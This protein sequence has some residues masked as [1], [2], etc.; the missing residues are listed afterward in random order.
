M[1]IEASLHS[2]VFLNFAGNRFHGLNVIIEWVQMH[3]ITIFIQKGVI[4]F[5]QVSDFILVVEDEFVFFY[6]LFFL[7]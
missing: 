7:S 2:L 5:S 6:E 3:S 1:G 4:F